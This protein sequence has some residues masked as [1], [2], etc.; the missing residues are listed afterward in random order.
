MNDFFPLFAQSAVLAFQA[1]WL[2]LAAHDNLRNP[3]IHER[4]FTAVLSMGPL[5]KQAPEEF[6]AI[7]DRKVDNPKTQRT[8][9]RALV[10]GEV[11]VAILLWLAAAGLL[12]A[13]LGLV[14]SSGARSLGMIAALGFTALWA[15]LLIGGVWFADMISA[16][17]AVQSH[18]TLVL[19]G[20]A[21]L[22][23]IAVAP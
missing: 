15:S 11:I 18:F 5:A 14:G 4:G 16:P 21:A 9:F 7:G 19:W 13:A 17:P 2:S 6:A 12:L 3:D 1:A 8:L 22:I 23:F 20:T 10:A